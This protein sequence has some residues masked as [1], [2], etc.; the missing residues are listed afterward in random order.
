MYDSHG[1]RLLTPFVAICLGITLIFFSSID[2]LIGLFSDYSQQVQKIAAFSIVTA[3]F[4]S[5]RFF[6]Q[7][8]MTLTNRNIV[9]KWF[10]KRRGLA[11][12]IMSIV[13]SAGFSSAAVFTKYLIDNY[14]WS[15]AWR[16]IAVFLI[17]V[18][19]P[20]SY[21][22]YRDSPAAE[23]VAP[24]G[25][26]DSTLY[27]EHGMDLIEAR[28]HSI[29]WVALSGLSLSSLLLTAFSFHIVAIFLEAG[30]SADTAIQ[31][32]LWIAVTSVA[33]TIVFSHLS[34]RIP[35]YFLVSCHLFSLVLASLGLYFLAVDSGY[36]L[37]VAGMGMSQGIHGILGALV[38]PYYFGT[39]HLG[40]ITGFTMAL[41]VFSSALG[42]VYFGLLYEIYGSFSTAALSAAV[43]AVVVFFI[44]ISSWHQKPRR[45]TGQPG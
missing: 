10:E 37:F 24:D 17:I 1:P 21:F 29:F 18:F 2:F 43:M 11:S 32:Y 25:G 40:S 6:G 23:G 8:M 34:D 26:G 35:L 15:G 13:V 12:G 38:W 22:F 41:M 7:G 33:T 19:A 16:I 9:M 28:S 42:P 20:L 3:G 36:L 31:S 27:T 30:S 4:I 5:L 45:F 14:Y 39:R 44:S